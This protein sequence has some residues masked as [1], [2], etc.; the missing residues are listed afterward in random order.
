MREVKYTTDGLHMVGQYFSP[1]SSSGLK[2]GVLVFPEAF[3]LGEHAL[4]RAR[5]LAEMGY[6]ALACDLQGG[7]EVIDDLSEVQRRL[8]DLRAQPHRIRERAAAA[9]DVLKAM[10]EVDTERLGGIGFCFGGTMA[11]ELARAGAA[12]RAVAGFHS[13]LSVASSTETTAIQARIL[14]CLGADDPVIS[15]EQRLA[16]EEEMRRRD[17]NWHMLLLG[18]VVH[19]FT[20]PAAD[21]RGKPDTFRYDADA[22][23]RSWAAMADLFQQAFA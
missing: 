10:P 21:L 11:L 12:L 13:A 23:R 17:A 2:P 14:V 6:A 5:R 19:S 8:S 16:F 3:G 15:V 18:G 4:E 20:D 7:G 22:D 9:L 1:L